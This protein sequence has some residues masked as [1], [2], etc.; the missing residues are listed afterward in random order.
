MS[1]WLSRIVPASA[2]RAG[3]GLGAGLSLDAS[4]D[5]SLGAGLGAVMVWFGCPVMIS[6]NYPSY[7]QSRLPRVLVSARDVTILALEGRLDGGT[8]QARKETVM[9]VAASAGQNTVSWT[10]HAHGR[11]DSLT[12]DSA[13]ARRGL[14]ATLNCAH[15]SA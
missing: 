8:R 12:H 1:R 14:W 2:R 15:V 11:H 10:G 7:H 3:L 13:Q 5:A 6:Q 4:L 9:S